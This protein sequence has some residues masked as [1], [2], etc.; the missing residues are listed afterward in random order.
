MAITALRACLTRHLCII[1]LYHCNIDEGTI[2]QID[3]ATLLIQARSEWGTKN[4]IQLSLQNKNTK[5]S[6]LKILQKTLKNRHFL[7]EL[8]N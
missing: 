8:Y 6:S 5:K 7:S 2:H 1:A 4:G 3:L